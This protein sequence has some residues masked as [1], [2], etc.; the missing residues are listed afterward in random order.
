[1]THNFLQVALGGAIGA[2][3][4]YGVNILAGR[5][6][7]GL[8]L[9]TLTVNVV[10]LVVALHTCLGTLTFSSIAL[11]AALSSARAASTGSVMP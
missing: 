10:G 1:M 5:I 2:S 6:A 8:P 3:A 4:R 11:S 7:P 9:G